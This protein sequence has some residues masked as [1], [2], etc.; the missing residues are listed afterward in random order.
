V[1]KKVLKYTKYELS[2]DGEIFV[3]YNTVTTVTTDSHS[4]ADTVYTDC[5]TVAAVNRCY[6]RQ[7]NWQLL[8]ERKS[9]CQNAVGSI[10]QV[11]KLICPAQKLTPQTIPIPQTFYNISQALFWERPT[12]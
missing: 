12:F 10:V 11:Q 1:L 6:R 3:N 2:T 9:E 5:L 7:I 4:I 8:A